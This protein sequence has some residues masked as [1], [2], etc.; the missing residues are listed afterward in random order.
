MRSRIKE[1]KYPIPGR[2]SLLG[3]DATVKG[4][5]RTVRNQKAFTFV[6]INDGSTLS[7]FQILVNAD[8]PKYEQ[9]INSLSTGVSI[10]A[11]GKIAESPGKQQEFELHAKEIQIIGDC[12]P[13]VY[14]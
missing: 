12:D 6:E 10:A 5:V 9:L 13:E 3:T 4:W 11:K 2:P 7:N 1:L 8:M 14:P